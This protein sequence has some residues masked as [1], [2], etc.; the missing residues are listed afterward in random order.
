ATVAMADPRTSRAFLANALA[1][2]LVGLLAAGFTFAVVVFFRHANLYAHDVQH[3]VPGQAGGWQG[4]MLAAVLLLSPV[5]LQLGPVP[6]LFTALIAT[7]LYA[8]TA[9]V[10]ASVFF[11]AALALS[12]LTAEKIGEVASFSGAATDV[13][14]VEHGDGTGL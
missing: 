4:R 2:L 1:I 9:E 14:L 3:L 7:A 10:V 13:W 12:P 11:L 8:T 5:L 6:L